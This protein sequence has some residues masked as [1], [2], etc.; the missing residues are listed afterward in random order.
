MELGM[1][2]HACNTS[3]LGGRGRRISNLRTAWAK[4]E[5]SCLKN[6]YKQKDLVQVVDS[7]F[8]MYEAWVQFRKPSKENRKSR[9]FCCSL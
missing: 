8:T 6:K 3:Y 2:E 7:M 5:R 9:L 4:L 1:V